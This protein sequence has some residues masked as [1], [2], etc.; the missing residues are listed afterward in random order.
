MA[1]ESQYKV[2]ADLVLETTRAQQQSRVMQRRIQ[3]L[4]RRIRGTSS[5]ASGLT[6]NLIAIGG[7]YVGI[8]AL[9][10]GFS[11]LTRGAVEYATELE[12]TRIGL[13]SVLSAVQN[14]D[15]ETAQRTS[16]KVFEQV[17]KDYG[18]RPRV[19]IAQA[20]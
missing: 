12:K 20:P 3:E 4:G 11:S 10:R 2:R 16:G 15:W 19:L 1:E 14:T 18:G 17:R 7:A 9:V 13:T 5:L 8:N 6:R